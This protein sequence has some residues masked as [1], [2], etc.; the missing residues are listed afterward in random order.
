MFLLDTNVL[1]ELPKPRPTP[2]VI[3]WLEAT[4][5]NSL[6]VSVLTIGEVLRGIRDLNRR[7]PMRA[8][9][10]QT[11]LDKV[12]NDFKSRVLP[13][14]ETVIEAWASLAVGRSLPA[15]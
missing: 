7:E 8:M 4:S 13:V 9:A 5:P 2:H 6:Y 10:L 14:D 12:R 15:F 11:W 1:S 3:R